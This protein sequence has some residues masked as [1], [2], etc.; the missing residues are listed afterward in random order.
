MR[1]SR[2]ARALLFTG[3]L[4]LALGV[5]PLWLTTSLPGITPPLLFIMAFYLL[6]PMGT[7]ITA[8]GLIL[9]AIARVQR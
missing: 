8:F 2:W 7:A 9:Y 5:L 1:L 3:L 4:L 6:A